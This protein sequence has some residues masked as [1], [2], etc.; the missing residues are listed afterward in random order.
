MAGSRTAGCWSTSM[1]R[2]KNS[3]A[4]QRLHLFLLSAALGMAVNPRIK[5]I[6]CQLGPSGYIAGVGRGCV[7][8]LPWCALGNVAQRDRIHNSLGYRPGARRERRHVW[9]MTPEFQ[10]EHCFA[11]RAACRA[12]TCPLSL[13]RP[14]LPR[15]EASAWLNRKTRSAIKYLKPSLLIFV[16]TA[17]VGRLFMK[18]R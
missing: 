2:A 13:L 1:L 18:A 7:G 14:L 6:L 4:F 15:P 17:M 5:E 8:R 12:A 9:R 16:K 10:R 3:A 11:A